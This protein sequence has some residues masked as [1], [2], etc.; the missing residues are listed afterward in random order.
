RAALLQVG[1]SLRPGGT[2]YVV[3]LILDDSRLTPPASARIN[4]ICLSFYD[5]GQAYTEREY[6]AWLTEAGFTDITRDASVAGSS[7]LRARKAG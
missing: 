2:I 3:G 5:G 6:R 4:V 7:V 1:Q